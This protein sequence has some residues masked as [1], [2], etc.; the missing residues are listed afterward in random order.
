MLFSFSL[1]PAFILIGYNGYMHM[2]MSK[3]IKEK[4]DEAFFVTQVKNEPSF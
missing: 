1:C 3:Y 4:S 2:S